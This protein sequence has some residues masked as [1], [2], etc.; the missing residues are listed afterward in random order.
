[1][2]RILVID[3]DENYRMILRSFVEEK[4]HTVWE[5]EDAAEGLKIFMQEKVDL[6][7]SD[8][9]MPNKTGLELL[10][11]LKSINSKVLFIMVTGYPS[12]DMA[13]ESMKAGAFDFLVKPVDINQL[14]AVMT[15]ALS[16]VELRTQ[17]TTLRG[18]NLALLLS[19]PLWIIIGILVR[20]FLF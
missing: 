3:D 10:K 2:A 14:A 12:V 13:T 1:M 7:I 5:A 8:F 20:V 4:G 9:M 6:V 19:I 11:E 16:T 15:R 18:V 17:L